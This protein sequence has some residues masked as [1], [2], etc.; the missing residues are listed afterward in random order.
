M[1]SPERF[2]N[3]FEG[4]IGSGRF[5]PFQ[6]IGTALAL[7]TARTNI[8]GANPL[9]ASSREKENFHN[10]LL[11]GLGKIRLDRAVKSISADHP[12]TGVAKLMRKRHR[13]GRPLGG[14][15]H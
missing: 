1:A 7:L 9:V 15:K 3:L 12:I 6:K 14:M 5:Q 4:K 8:H 11:A 2:K 13:L 10:L